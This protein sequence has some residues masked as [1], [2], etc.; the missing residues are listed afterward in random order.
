MI[1]GLTGLNAAGKGTVA[2]F[3][4]QH[5]FDYYSLSDVI[6][7]ALAERGEEP[8]RENMIRA[9][10]AIREQ[11]GPGAL[12]I[13]MLKKVD[14][15]QNTIVDSFR[16]PAEVR[17]FQTLGDQFALIEVTASEE[18]RFTRIKSRGRVGDP[19]DIA[20]FRE[21][22]QRELT[23]DPTG[24]QLVATAALADHRVSNDGDLARLHT[25]LN[26]LLKTLLTTDWGGQ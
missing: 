2:D 21:L 3:L 18:T 6:R 17:E 16:N 7:D 4:K 15:D 26:D 8:A 19:T 22:E 10:N 14:H 1:I 9:G 24:Q 20:T 12:A 25:Q 23:G 11:G 5:G 13:G